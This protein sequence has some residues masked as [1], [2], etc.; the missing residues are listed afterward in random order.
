MLCLGINVSESNEKLSIYFLQE[1]LENKKKTLDNLT[2]LSS[3][4]ESLFHINENGWKEEYDK[5]FENSLVGDMKSI[6]NKIFNLI[7]DFNTNE[8]TILTWCLMK[9]K[10]KIHQIFF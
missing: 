4:D 8:L 3:P 6:K 9:M 5:M 10:S 1:H 2:S 7:D